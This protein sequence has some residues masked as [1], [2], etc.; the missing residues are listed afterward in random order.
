MKF[1]YIDEHCKFCV[2]F[3]SISRFFIHIVITNTLTDIYNEAC[4]LYFLC[5]GAE[6]FIKVYMTNF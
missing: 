5:A 2:F 3:W 6:V 4:D 1:D